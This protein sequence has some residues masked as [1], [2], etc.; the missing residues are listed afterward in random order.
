V[1]P[2][3]A[4]RLRAAELV[5]RVTETGAH[6]NVLLDR[7]GGEGAARGTVTRLTMD[8]LRWMP[9]VD[10]QLD[11]VSS[12]PLRTLDPMV[13]SLLRV[14]V[15]ELLTGAAPHAVVD[16][17]VEAVREAGIARAAGFVNAVL[18][19]VAAGPDIPSRDRIGEATTPRWI[20]ERLCSAWG[21]E[22]AAAFLTAALTPAAIGVRLRPGS[23]AIGEPVS[24]IPGAAWLTSHADAV[25]ADPAAVVMDPSSTAVALAV[26]AAP[27]MNV[28]D[29]A[30]A[31]GNKTGALWDAMSGEGHLVAADR[32]P[33]RSRSAAE[34]LRRL[35]MTPSWVVADGARPPFAVGSFDR[36]LV[37]A[38]CTGLGTLRRRPEIKLRL[39]PGAPA[40]LGATQRTIVEAALPLVKPGGCLVYAVCTVF[41]EE[42][43]E[44]AASFGG[45]PPHDL[46]G[47]QW[48]RGTLLAP[49]LTGT[50]GMFVTVFDT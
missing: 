18:R 42:T 21:A 4:N 36:I 45:R 20:W 30:A 28:L 16:S 48:G 49:H 43:V 33:R 11:A 44:I 41:P 1:K 3:V 7:V 8:T 22:E 15:T 5:G 39:D 46:P 32:H 24:G 12:R 27:G 23:A 26:Q 9:L 35:G 2:G 50:D 19:R 6:S 17:A 13:R 37:D 40:E 34:R 31:P 10:G 29:V 38:P 47:R 14:A 25:E